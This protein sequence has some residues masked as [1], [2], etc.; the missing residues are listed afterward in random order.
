MIYVGGID[1]SGN[2]KKYVQDAVLNGWDSEAN[3]YIKLFEKAFA[4]YVGAKYA[5]SVSGGTQAL[6]LACATLGIGPGDEVIL[7]DITYFACSDVI[8]LLG[9]TPVFV[10]VDETWCI[11]PEAFEKSIT[12]KTKA[13]MPVWLYGN[14]PKMNEIITIANNY[15]LFVV[16]DACPAVGSLYHGRHAGTFGDFGCF[17]FHGAKIMTTGFGGMLVTDNEDLYNQMEFLA[18]H[19]ENKSLPYRFFQEDIGYS[20]DLPNMNCAFGLA[21]IER[22]EKFV[23]R[24]REIFNW[25]QEGLQDLDLELNYEQKYCRTN[26]W[27]TSIIGDYDRKM[28]MRTLKENGIDSR[29]FF[30][31][32]SYFPMYQEVWTPE[33]HRIGFSGI[34]L[35]SGVQRT[36]AEIDY[37][38]E[39]L[40]TCLH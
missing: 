8:K 22:I 9:A 19:G 40:R 14:S 7:P 28:V 1:R 20:F 24:K 39:F 30:F 36:K 21:Q 6:T 23:D 17:S 4:K 31:P 13:V 27:M 32:I 11:S 29:P 35:P 10:D 18:D 26:K 2:E 38:C 12:P 5:R 34:S 3:K 25:Y 16:E 33:A 37:I 15:G